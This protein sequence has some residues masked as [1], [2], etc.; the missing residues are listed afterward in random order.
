MTRRVIS[1][2]PESTM[3]PQEK[4]S[5]TKGFLIM[6]KEGKGNKEKEWTVKKRQLF[7]DN[8][9]SWFKITCLRKEVFTF[10]CGNVDSIMAVSKLWAPSACVFSH[11]ALR[12]CTDR[13]SMDR[14]S[15]NRL[16]NGINERN[17]THSLSSWQHC[18]IDYKA[19]FRL[20][21]IFNVV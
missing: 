18:Q 4:S 21:L 11:K 1:L 20:G 6:I 19:L 7:Q 3:A 10:C 9:E 2:C 12:S 16:W 13:L 17:R 8:L 15:G 5:A 14:G